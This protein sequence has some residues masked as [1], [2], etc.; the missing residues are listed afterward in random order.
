MTDYR[1]LTRALG[2]D[3]TALGSR[4][5]IGGTVWHRVVLPLF[6]TDGIHTGIQLARRTTDGVTI[7]VDSNGNS[8]TIG[9]YAASLK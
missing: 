5:V 8:A 4:V 1:D 2:Y 3:L 6:P 9:R 7:T